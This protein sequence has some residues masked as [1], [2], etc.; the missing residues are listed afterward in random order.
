MAAS[1]AKL[2]NFQSRK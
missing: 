2:N 1:K